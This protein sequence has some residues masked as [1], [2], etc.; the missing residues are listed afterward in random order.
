MSRAWILTTVQVLPIDN[1]LYCCLYCIYCYCT[2]HYCTP[3]TTNFDFVEQCNSSIGQ[4]PRTKQN[5]TH[6]SACLLGRTGVA[7]LYP[8]RRGRFCFR[9]FRRNRLDMI[10][11]QETRLRTVFPREKPDR[12]RRLELASGKMVSC[13]DERYRER[14]STLDRSLFVSQQS[15]NQKKESTCK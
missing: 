14:E 1:S 3:S 13:E 8:T 10:R 7:G 12:P 5:A 6:F 9:G 2:M 15:I 11:L 4:P